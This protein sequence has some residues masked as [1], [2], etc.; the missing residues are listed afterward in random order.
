MTERT[1]R[2]WIR[3]EGGPVGRPPYPADVRRRIFRIVARVWLRLPPRTGWR[4]I[5]D[6]LGRM[7]PTGLVQESLR[8]IKRLHDLHEERRLAHRRVHVEVLAAGV[9]WHQDS[10]HLGRVGGRPSQAEILRD[11]A[12]PEVLAASAGG[13]VRGRDAVALLESAIAA[14]V[15]AGNAPP[16]VVSTDNGPA[17]R[18]KDFAACVARHRIVH[19]R[20][21]P[22]TPQHNAR[23]ERTIRDVKS[24]SGLGRGVVLDSFEEA[25]SRVALACERLEALARIRAGAQPLTVQYTQDQR[26]RFHEAVCWRIATAVQC[27]RGARAQ[28]MAEREAVFA[29]LEERGLIHRTRGGAALGGRKAE[30][31][32]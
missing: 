3:K 26:D 23:A 2:N 13:V 9:L 21:L 29:E 24:A 8:E 27:A 32:S 15:L 11:A 30:R 20:N 25:Q 22:R 19:L 28:R 12:R 16:L 4:T 17:Y 18:S 31:V 1:I 6:A 7:V 10:T 5:R 14:E